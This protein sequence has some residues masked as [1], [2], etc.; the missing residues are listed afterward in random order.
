MD[1]NQPGQIP[2]GFRTHASTRTTSA[3]SYASAYSSNNTCHSQQTTT[4]T[5]PESLAQL[6]F[7][8][9]SVR[10]TILN[11]QFYY[12]KKMFRRLQRPWPM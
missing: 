11:F 4:S 12:F 10:N 8:H 9:Q 2:N 1:F 7:E 5:P 3:R 6:D